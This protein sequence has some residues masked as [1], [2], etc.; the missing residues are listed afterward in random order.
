MDHSTG[1]SSGF[2]ADAACIYGSCRDANAAPPVYWINAAAEA[3]AAPF[4]LSKHTGE[5]PRSRRATLSA[6]RI[7]VA[8]AYSSE[9]PGSAGPSTSSSSS[10]W[11]AIQ[12]TETT[13]SSSAVSNTFTPPAPRERNEMPDTGQ[14][15]D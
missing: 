9:A 8:R 3:P 6:P 15:I 4:S 13:R 7:P 11:S 2:K 10:P 14:R 1:F 12:A 5:L